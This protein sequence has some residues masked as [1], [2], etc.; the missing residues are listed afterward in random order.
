LLLLSSV[1]H[2][3]SQV[4]IAVAIKRAALSLSGNDGCC[5]QACSAFIVRKRLLLLSS[6]QHFHVQVK[7]AVAIWRAAL[8]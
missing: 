1:Y 7:I 3:H 4:K 6:V 2:F 8:S 5:Y